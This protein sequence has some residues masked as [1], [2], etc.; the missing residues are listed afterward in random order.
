MRLGHA[1]FKLTVVTVVELD[2]DDELLELL[3]LD[4][5]ITGT[6][7][8]RVCSSGRRVGRAAGLVR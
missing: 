5:G 4:V 2:D 6:E 7:Q 8:P 1:A 3:V